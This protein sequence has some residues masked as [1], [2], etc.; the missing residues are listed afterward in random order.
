MY[1]HA[2][3]TK[4][5]TWKRPIEPVPAAR[6][7]SPLAPLESGKAEGKVNVGRFCNWWL[8]EKLNACQSHSSRVGPEQRP[9]PSLEKGL[10][11]LY[12]TAIRDLVG[13]NSK[14]YLP[15]KVFKSEWG[16]L[17]KADQDLLLRHSHDPATNI[18]HLPPP[19]GA[20]EVEEL[21]RKR[22]PSTD[23][24]STTKMARR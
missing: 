1:Y 21:G 14:A 19:W 9:P 15:F 11:A 8:H 4:V 5:T 20:T 3:S 13:W 6:L 10:P 24:L 16:G 7:A 12:A 22:G 2:A 17:S 23:L 18:S